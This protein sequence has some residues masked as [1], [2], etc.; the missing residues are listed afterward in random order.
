MS[1][2]FLEMLVTSNATSATSS[3][4]DVSADPY[5][6]SKLQRVLPIGTSKTANGM[7]NMA[8]NSLTCC[9]PFIVQIEL[10]LHKLFNITPNNNI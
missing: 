10:D 9:F 7:C 6:V 8:T 1:S 4:T 5:N 2:D 3:H